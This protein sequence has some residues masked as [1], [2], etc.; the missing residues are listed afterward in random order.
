[1]DLERE[2]IYFASEVA[3]RQVQY[4]EA[5]TLVKLL[6]K[7]AE[8]GRRTLGIREDWRAVISRMNPDSSPL[9]KKIASLIEEGEALSDEL[10][11][12]QIEAFERK[13]KESK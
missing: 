10:S 13:Q 5:L 4:S 8:D 2:L 11:L 12:L 1:M 9:V 7:D 6:S 3:G